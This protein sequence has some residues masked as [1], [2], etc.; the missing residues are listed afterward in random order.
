MPQKHDNEFNFSVALKVQKHYSLNIKIRRVGF[1][2]NPISNKTL[3]P[4]LC[5]HEDHDKENTRMYIVL[6]SWPGF[7]FYG[8]PA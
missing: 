6:V 3:V 1:N 7:I 5:L 4:I 8:V 2:E